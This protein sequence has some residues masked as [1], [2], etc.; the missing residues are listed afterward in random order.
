[1]R[2]IKLLE[3]SS[4]MLLLAGFLF[5]SILK[6]SGAGH[7]D[8]WIMIWSGKSLLAKGWFTNYNFDYQ[9]IAS[10]ILMPAVAAFSIW[11]SEQ[12]TLVVYKL[13]SAGFSLLGLLVLFAAIKKVMA[14][15]PYKLPGL[16][17]VVVSFLVVAMTASAP[18][19]QYWTFGG[20][21][22]SL[23]FLCLVL[24]ATDCC[25]YVISGETRFIARLT[26]WSIAVSLARVEGFLI[27]IGFLA[28]YTTL[29]C[30]Q[31]AVP[32]K[33]IKNLSF[34]IL[35]TLVASV[36]VMS[37][38]YFLSGAL[39]PNPVYSKVSVSM[40]LL[41]EGASYWVQ[42][43]TDSLWGYA[44]GLATVISLIVLAVR[45]F[46]IRINSLSSSMIECSTICSILLVVIELFIVFSGGNWMGYFRFFAPIVFLKNVLLAV[47]LYG[48]VSTY[49]YKKTIASL[50]L[51]AM[52]LSLEQ[53]QAKGFV[54]LWAGG[55]A[56]CSDIT[57]LDELSWNISDLNS[58]VLKKNCAYKRD[59]TGIQPFLE[60]YLGHI[61]KNEGRR[62]VFASYQAG[63]FPFTLRK[64]FNPD[65]VYF[66]DTVGLANLDVA[67][68]PGPKNSI[69][70]IDGT[71]LANL[72]CGL[73]GELSQTVLAHQVDLVYAL[74]IS[75][76]EEKTLGSC[77]F[78][79]IYRAPGA[80]VLASNKLQS[81]GT[82]SLINGDDG[83]TVS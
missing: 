44:Y 46:G 71:S 25:Q 81:T 61:I 75:D 83:A 52:L 15:A 49:P 4:L 34:L 63:F 59:A 23:Y 32:R 56:S 36:M 13:I 48:L 69:G 2:S 20:L 43:H 54:N 40:S 16:P 12:N 21:E 45:A 19:L 73:S 11:I 18:S 78:R 72:M 60:N 66:L 1:M 80:V 58:L 22:T 37:L 27:V 7:D 76:T 64:H 47:F 53:A 28:S 14:S 65:E 8:T 17:P 68:T 6:F 67:R 39:W 3:Y 55:M 10:S 79:V 82:L 42:F 30:V 26:L 50:Y 77:G 74:A 62:L 5:L 38:R 51:L 24:F 31:S 29:L 57:R 35:L 33:T 41:G 9:E 70:H